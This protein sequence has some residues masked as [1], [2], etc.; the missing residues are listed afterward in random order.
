MFWKCIGV[1]LLTV[2]VKSRARALPHAFGLPTGSLPGHLQSLSP[3]PHRSCWLPVWKLGVLSWFIPTW[4]YQ[5]LLGRISLSPL[6]SPLG[7]LG[8]PNPTQSWSSSYL[9]FIISGVFH[10]QYLWE[11]IRPSSALAFLHLFTPHPLVTSSFSNLSTLCLLS[12][13]SALQTNTPNYF[14]ASFGW[15]SFWNP[16][17]LKCISLTLLFNPSQL[18][19]VS[20]FSQNHGTIHIFFHVSL[21]AIHQ[22]TSR[23][24]LL[25]PVLQLWPSSRPNV[26]LPRLYS[27]PPW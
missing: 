10:T 3:I 21:N 15:M 24:Q 8:L 20:S 25:Q 12:S 9:S 7:S 23:L 22:Q 26:L 6:V 14:L 1:R 16:T 27:H 4:F 17:S 5:R 19:P 18:M 13:I 2:P 11:R